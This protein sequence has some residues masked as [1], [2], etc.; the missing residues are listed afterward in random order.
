VVGSVTSNPQSAAKNAPILTV[1]D[2]ARYR[3]LLLAKRDKLAAAAEGA[4]SLVPPPN[5]KS[6]DLLDWARADTEAESQ[7]QRRQSDAHLVRAIEDALTRI[8]RGSFGVCE[9]CQQPIPK[10]RLD[11]VPWTRV[12]RDCKEES[13][14][15]SGDRGGG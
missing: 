1:R 5:D 4:E 9:V 3:A 12:C 2:A 14:R 13:D 7:I 6:G 11:A 15:N 10:A 8:N